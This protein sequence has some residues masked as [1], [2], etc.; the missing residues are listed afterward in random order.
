MKQ[1]LYVLILPLLASC[2]LVPDEWYDD[3]L[4]SRE[5]SGP[6][7]SYSILPPPPETV[8]DGS[9]NYTLTAT[10]AHKNGCRAARE[11]LS[12]PIFKP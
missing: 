7:R 3:S 5:I 1:A 6:V 9:I 10:L 12:K 4:S 2:A 8:F 11:I